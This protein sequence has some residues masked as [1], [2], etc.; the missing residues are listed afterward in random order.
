MKK[1]VFIV[2][3]LGFINVFVVMIQQKNL[4]IFLYNNGIEIFIVY[5]VDGLNY[6][7]NGGRGVIFCFISGGIDIKGGGVSVVCDV[8][9]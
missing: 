6:C 5:E 2:V 8:L 3:V 9:C 7:Y 4:F 1:F